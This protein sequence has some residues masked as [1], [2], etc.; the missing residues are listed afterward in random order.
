VRFEHA[1]SGRAVPLAHCHRIKVARGR[2]RDLSTKSVGIGR[3]RH[4]DAHRIELGHLSHADV[5]GAVVWAMLV[6]LAVRKVNGDVYS[7]SQ[8]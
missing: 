2:S 8:G 6:M 4:T 5:S 1:R 3:E 7:R